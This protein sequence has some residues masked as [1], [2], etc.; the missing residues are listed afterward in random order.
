MYLD[1]GNTGESHFLDQ[2]VIDFLPRLLR[3]VNVNCV[4]RSYKGQ[5]VGGREVALDELSPLR[6][7]PP[8]CALF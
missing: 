8:S 1:T 7:G 6:L 5:F 4:F 3:N 2:I